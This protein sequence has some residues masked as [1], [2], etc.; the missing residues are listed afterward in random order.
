MQTDWG[1]PCKYSGWSVTLPPLLPGW[2]GH[3]RGVVS[4]QGDI[5]TKMWDLA[6]D[7]GSLITGAIVGQK[8][9]TVLE[10][11]NFMLWW[12]SSVGL[13]STVQ[14]TNGTVIHGITLCLTRVW[15]WSWHA[16]ESPTRWSPLCLKEAS[17]TRPAVHEGSSELREWKSGL[18]CLATSRAHP[19]ATSTKTKAKNKIRIVLC[20]ELTWMNVMLMKWAFAGN[21]VCLTT[22][23]DTLP[24][25]SELYSQGQD[26]RM[27]KEMQF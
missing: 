11:N 2:S 8:H 27:A 20:L 3:I 10:H 25:W 19:H 17:T 4:H 6:P 9:T 26:V 7:V 13:T 16:G 15:G 12:Y 14:C 1:I 22:A 23:A 18:A 24:Q 21:I 5:Y